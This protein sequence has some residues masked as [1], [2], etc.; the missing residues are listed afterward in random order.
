ML[1]SH[2]LH[3]GNPVISKSFSLRLFSKVA[4]N[5]PC[6]S[7]NE[8]WL[9]NLQDQAH[10]KEHCIVNPND[11]A[12]HS[13]DDSQTHNYVTREE[14]PNETDFFK[15]VS[16]P[17]DSTFI[18]VKAPLSKF[19]SVNYVKK[20][21]HHISKNQGLVD[22]RIIKCKSG[23]GGNGSVSFFRDAGR[24]IGPPDGGDGGKGGSIYVQAV[25]GLNSLAKL[26]TSYIASNGADG[27]ANQLDGAR[28]KDVLISVPVGTVVRLA[29]DPKVVRK[30][31]GESEGSTEQ[32]IRQVLDNVEVELHCTGK[33]K[34]DQRP[35]DIQLFRNAYSG[36]D[37]WIFKGK[38][39]EYHL[40]KAWFTELDEK[41]KVY[42][43]EQTESETNEDKFPLRGLD[44]S[45]P[46]EKPVCI[47]RGGS[48]GLGNMHFLTNMIRNPRFAKLGRAGLEQF[49][50]FEMKTIADLGL[51]GLPNAGKSTILNRIS[52]ARPR[53]GHWEFTTLHPI[54]GTVMK[55]AVTT[56]FTVAD[57]PGIIEGA[58]KDKGMGLDFLRHTERSKGWVIVLDLSRP[59]PLDDLNILLHELGGIK[60]VSKKNVLVVCNKVDVKMIQ[61]D[62]GYNRFIELK[63]FCLKNNW[64]IVPISARKGDNIDV[65]IE[66]MMTCARLT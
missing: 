62:T 55:D 53:I 26:K 14:R 36:G 27:A 10:R 6:A 12:N 38:D 3:F 23:V 47:L 16:T 37:G 48:G 22:L 64:D 13:S 57:I 34:M 21:Q 63:E 35:T 28:G 5:A 66:K 29:M 44:L 33:F 19:T 56:S 45:I 1:R 11:K 59:N 31:I 52:N 32:P 17:P 4:D 25:R 39:K 41:V 54:I 65:L 42:E 9:R 51:V 40:S 7:D 8:R 18:N 46:P 58:S 49:F 24:A 15:I 50:I 60:R 43:E 20:N 30:I 2:S 61:D